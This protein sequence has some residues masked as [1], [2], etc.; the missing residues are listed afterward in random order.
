MPGRGDRFRR[1]CGSSSFKVIQME[2]WFQEG[3]PPHS[4]SSRIVAEP[5]AEKRQL[6][7]AA[8]TSI[9]AR[10]ELFELLVIDITAIR[11]GFTHL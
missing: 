8:D 2:P 11:A 6:S 3:S 7:A 4:D 1:R 5:P 9:G 10:V